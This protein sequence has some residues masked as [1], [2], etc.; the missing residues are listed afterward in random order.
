MIILISASGLC[1]DGGGGGGGDDDDD[2]ILKIFAHD[3]ALGS[4]LSGWEVWLHPQP[5]ESPPSH[6]WVNY[7]VTCARTSS[8][9]ERLTSVS[10]AET[11]VAP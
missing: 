11:P 9:S 10:D 7:Q 1:S 6:S 5:E 2:S 8:P 4:L 3:R